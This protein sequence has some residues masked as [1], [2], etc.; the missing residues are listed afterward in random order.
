MMMST[1]RVTVPEQVLFRDLAGEAVLLELESGRYFG[2]N[3]TGT[4]MWSLLVQ[5]G[6]LDAALSALLEEYDVP[7][8]RLCSELLGFV[9]TVA[10]HNLLTTHEE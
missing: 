2:L 1:I 10:A 4:R 3:E 9:K 8:E 6:R 7:E 5:H